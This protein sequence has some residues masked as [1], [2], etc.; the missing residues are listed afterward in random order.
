MSKEKPEVCDVWEY[1]DK[2]YHVSAIT[3]RV[4]EVWCRSSDDIMR[5]HNWII[6]D[7]TTVFNYLGKSKVSIK[8]LFDV[9]D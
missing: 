6:K 2:L 9:K 3:D 4:V 5:K 8:G 7:F 1:Q